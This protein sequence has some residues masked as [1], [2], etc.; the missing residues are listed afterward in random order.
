[1]FFFLF[2]VYFRVILLQVT[3][4]QFLASEA[5]STSD[6]LLQ[7]P[8]ISKVAQGVL[9]VAIRSATIPGFENYL[10]SLNPIHFPD[11]NFLQEFWQKEFGCSPQAKR[12]HATPPSSYFSSPFNTKLDHLLN[13]SSSFPAKGSLQKAS[14]PPCSGTESLE[15]V[16]NP[17]TDTSQL[18]VSYNVYLAVY[19]AA[20]ALHSLLS[21]PNRDSSPGNNS[22]TCASP[23]HIKPIEVN[24]IKYAP[25]LLRDA[26]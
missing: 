11:D 13:D 10:R 9:G 20:H 1:M 26:F 3:D 15:R 18:R 17:F 4:R 7:D 25:V 19:A 16:Q 5:W 8:A 21:C 14:L 6:E 22:S 24:T 2:V 23:K 12:S